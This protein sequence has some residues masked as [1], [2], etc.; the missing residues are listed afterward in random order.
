M[1]WLASARRP[2][3]ILATTALALIPPVVAVGVGASDCPDTSKPAFARSLMDL[4]HA[5]GDVM[6]SPV[7][8]PQVDAEGDVVQVTT[9][10]LAAYRPDGVSVFA[11]GEDHWALTASGLETWTG[12]WH[13]G[14]Y[15]PPTLTPAQDHAPPGPAAPASVEA[16]TVLR[17]RGDVSNT[18]VVQDGAGSTY[19]V[20]TAS[21]C[22]D[23][24][25]APGDHI[26]IRTG[27]SQTDLILLPED[28]TCTVA[29]MNLAAGD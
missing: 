23:A 24:L 22:R 16:M 13:N 12:N 14:L 25:V 15:P 28:E 27:E 29:Q 10:G 9:T 3:I 4:Q 11:S 26:F 2:V 19:S 1:R 17:V 7:A 20:E 5:L 8:C 6:G 18:V 21:G